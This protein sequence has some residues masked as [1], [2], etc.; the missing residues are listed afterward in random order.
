MFACGENS[1]FS[2]KTGGQFIGPFKSISTRRWASIE[3]HD[4]CDP[5][6]P[7]KHVTYHYENNEQFSWQIL[8]PTKSE[9]SNQ[10]VTKAR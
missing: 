3:M 9:A 10:P 5:Q 6:S 8:G 2:K 7:I 4:F 1:S